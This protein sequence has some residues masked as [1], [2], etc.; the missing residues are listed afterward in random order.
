MAHS[1]LPDGWS[2]LK[3]TIILGG[4]KHGTRIVGR[5]DYLE[6]A[7]CPPIRWA[8]DRDLFETLTIKRTTYRM[9]RLRFPGGR[10]IP[11]YVHPD[12]SDDTAERLL[13]DLVIAAWERAA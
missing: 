6:M 12:I 10:H 7:E 3:P 5:Y 8:D 1:A 4:P 13:A 11:A 2:V 9:K